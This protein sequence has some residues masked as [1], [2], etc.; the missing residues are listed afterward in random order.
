MA[1]DCARMAALGCHG[2]D[3]RGGRRPGRANRVT[4]Q[5]WCIGDVGHHN[6]GAARSNYRV[7]G[8]AACL[9]QSTR[10]CIDARFGPRIAPRIPSSSPRGERT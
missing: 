5:P 9:K 3:Q 2:A 1:E 6:C 8:M 7:G 10:R 4:G